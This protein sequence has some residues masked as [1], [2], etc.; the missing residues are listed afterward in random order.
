[1]SISASA[2]DFCYYTVFATGILL[3]W[4]FSSSRVLFALVT[5]LLA[6]RALEFFSGGHAAPAGPGRIAFEVVGFLL[7]L[8]FI[9][10]SFMRERGFNL[11]TVAPRIFLLFV[12]S[13]IV[14]VLCRPGEVHGPSLL[15]PGFL[16]S[17][18]LP[19][20][21]IPQFALLAFA[22]AFGFLLARFWLYRKPVESGLL[23]SLV[24]T[25]LA[26]Q[27]GG[28]GRTASLFIA[29]AGLVLVSSV[30]E[31]SYVLAYYDELTALPSRRAFNDALL[32][33]D[34]SYA[35]A[36]VDIDH[37][38]KFNDT[39]GHETGDQVLRMVAARL[40]RV[41]GGGQAFRVGG[42]EFSVL[43]QG[44]SMKD[45]AKHLEW[46]R[47]AIQ[48]STFSV[49]G[50]KERRHAPSRDPG[51]R[52]S[53]RRKTSSARR[54]PEPAP[55]TDFAINGLAVTVSIGVAE[56]TRP[57]SPCRRSDP[58]GRQ[59]L[60]SRQTCRTEPGRNCNHGAGQGKTEHRLTAPVP[61]CTFVVLWL[62]IVIRLRS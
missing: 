17:H 9:A 15:R 20:L 24:A 40:A 58:R 52:V 37:F 16:D 6:H 14:A 42:E 53:N 55:G 51:R 7:P 50:G 48:T 21:R 56:P 18:L 5:L 13:V 43:F 23:W 57:D 4:R 8:N 19:W 47:T 27:L 11:A 41:T 39:Y 34:Q 31:N 10:L 30:I 25:F 59:S 49:R 29:T 35:I 28:I 12:E 44:K 54:L 46:L 22:V 32:H 38:K 3:A 60:V 36:V 26:L 45:A 62:R 33:L 61:A 2:A 1:M